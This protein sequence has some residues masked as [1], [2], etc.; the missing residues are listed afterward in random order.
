MIVTQFNK[1]NGTFVLVWPNSSD[2][3]VLLWIDLHECARAYQRIKGVIV[4][5]DISIEDSLR[6]GLLKQE[7]G[8][9]TQALEHATHESRFFQGNLRW[10][11]WGCDD[12][13][14]QWV[15]RQTAQVCVWE[16]HESPFLAKIG[17]V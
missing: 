7:K 15:K 2:Y 10:H 14:F 16:S 8:H 12:K 9:F 3:F 1:I 5:T 17:D 13:R 6:V 11:A 4:G